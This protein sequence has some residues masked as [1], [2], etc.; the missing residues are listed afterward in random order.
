MILVIYVCGHLMCVVSVKKC[1]NLEAKSP[2]LVHVCNTRFPLLR[3]R[4]ALHRGYSGITDIQVG[5]FFV[6]TRATVQ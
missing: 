4:S 5:L 2:D 6:L 1:E 3:F